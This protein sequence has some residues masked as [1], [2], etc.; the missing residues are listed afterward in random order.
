VAPVR[1]VIEH[2]ETITG[3]A[4]SGASGFEQPGL[5]GYEASKPIRIG[6]AAS[7]QFQLDVY[8][9]VAGVMF[10]GAELLGRVEP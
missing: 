2:V 8:G 4:A 6:N 3:S 1:A 7:E 9:E 5:S 10:L